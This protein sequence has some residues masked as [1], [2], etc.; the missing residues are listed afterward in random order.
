MVQRY[1]WT[2]SRSLATYAAA[3]CLANVPKNALPTQ[4]LPVSHHEWVHSCGG[5]QV[6]L[7]LAGLTAQVS[8]GNGSSAWCRF[9]FH[10]LQSLQS[11]NTSFYP[12]PQQA[13]R[14]V[15]SCH[16]NRYLCTSNICQSSQHRH[17][18]AFG[19]PNSRFVCI[20]MDDIALYGVSLRH[21]EASAPVKVEVDAK[22]RTTR[23]SLWD[24]ASWDIVHVGFCSLN[25]KEM[26]TIYIYNDEHWP[27]LL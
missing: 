24:P 11:F 10:A 3:C 20:C 8:S 21:C 1:L 26:R 9:S 16:W 14:M 5:P 12:R 4:F 25:H 6:Q 17:A 18:K 22:S 2:L 7:A 27:F 13:R 15:V 23:I 19:D